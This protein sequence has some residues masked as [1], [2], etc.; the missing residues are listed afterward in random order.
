MKF[1]SLLD[2][3]PLQDRH[4]RDLNNFC[5]VLTRMTTSYPILVVQDDVKLVPKESELGTRDRVMGTLYIV[6]H[7][8]NPYISGKGRARSP[9]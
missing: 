4:L 9:R 3:F 8:N 1:Q 6:L 5:A 7:T 2:T